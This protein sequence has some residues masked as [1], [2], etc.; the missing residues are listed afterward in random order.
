MPRPGTPASPRS[1]TAIPFAP[2]TATACSTS[3]RS[4][5]ADLVVVGPEAPLVAGVAD[6]LRHVGV[7]VF[8]PSAEP[9]R[10][11]GSKSFAKDVMRAADV[12][13]AESL[14]D[15]APPVRDQG[16]R[17]RGGEGRL[18]LP[19]QAELDAAL[20]AA[21]AFGDSIVIEELLDGEELSRLR[22]LRRCARGAAPGRAGL[23]APRARETEGPNT[24]GM[25]SFSP[26][27]AGAAELEDI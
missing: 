25:G 12:P 2:R 16:R 13:T 8:G 9:P 6:E 4:L 19:R 18:R 3:R 11:E 17:P 14:A 23:Q 24:G 21:S 27:P 1:A 7:P 10:I 20:Q 22:A 5:E 26:V 15:R